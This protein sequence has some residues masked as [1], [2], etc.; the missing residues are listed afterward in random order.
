MRQRESVSSQPDHCV[1]AR[2]QP[3]PPLA[4]HP[5]TATG[6]SPGCQNK[7]NLEGKR[8]GVKKETM[9]K[10]NFLRAFYILPRLFS[11]PLVHEVRVSSLL[12]IFLSHKVDDEL[13]NSLGIYLK[14]IQLSE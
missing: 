7:D 4:L 2:T 14:E 8:N 9:L 5:P 12:S 10:C 13:G 11:F 6:S 1:P 3:V